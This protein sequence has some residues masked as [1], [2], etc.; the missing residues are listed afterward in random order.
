[1]RDNDKILPVFNYYNKFGS[2]KYVRGN[3]SRNVY[4]TQ[5]SHVNRVVADTESWE[6]IAAKTLEELPEVISYVKNAFLGFTV[7]YVAE[8]K[9]KQYFP[10]FI[11]RCKAGKD[12]TINLII[13]ITGMER[14]KAEK[15][16]YLTNRWLPAV[17]AVREKY[18]YDE[19]YFIEIAKDIR[20]IRNQLR[21]KIKESAKAFS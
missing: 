20:D 8:G 14:E 12:K 6:Q 17:N 3:T 11:A 10:D 16:W 2:T 1:M 7:P 4:E 18:E 5:K 19:W 13:E 9:D 21:A 15:K